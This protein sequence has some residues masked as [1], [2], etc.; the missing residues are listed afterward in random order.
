MVASALTLCHRLNHGWPFC[1]LSVLLSNQIVRNVRN[2]IH[3]WL[4]GVSV[5]RTSHLCQSLFYSVAAATRISP[6]D[7]GCPYPQSGARSAD[8]SQETLSI[9]RPSRCV[10]PSWL[11]SVDS[12]D[13]CP[14]RIV[15]LHRSNILLISHPY[16]S[17]DA[18]HLAQNCHQSWP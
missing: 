1:A 10:A 17:S 15:L 8:L 7:T 18:N 16:I 4:P 3:R 13:K 9:P 11:Y 12:C 6:A 2:V 5:P 14:H